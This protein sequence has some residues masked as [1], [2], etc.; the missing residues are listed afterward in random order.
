MYKIIDIRHTG[1]FG[2]RGTKRR[3]N[4]YRKRIGRT[5]TDELVNSSKPGNQLILQYVTDENG[6]DYS[7]KFLCCS[8]LVNKSIQG[9]EVFLET[10][11][12][13]YVLEKI[14][15]KKLF[16]IIGRTSSGKTSLTKAVAKR[17][18]LKVVK[19][20]TTRPLRPG[21]IEKESDHYFI[22]EEEYP[23]YKNDI[24][25]YTE[26]NGYRYFTTSKELEECDMYVIDP[27]GYYILSNKIYSGEYLKGIKTIPIYIS[28]PYDIAKERAAERGDDLKAWD[29]RY[30]SENAQFSEFE[31]YL[32]DG[33]LEAYA[34]HN[35]GYFGDIVG[36]MK[37]II[38]KEQGS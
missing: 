31:D 12:S 6:N 32:V 36:I 38:L 9:D 7:D 19:S 11:N 8:K 25:A 28:T 4:P 20:Y 13:I 37:N 35:V 33:S 24:V 29:E 2:E 14:K 15:E 23:N 22:S 3:E 18:N 16:C 5:V 17:L 21:E 1:S 30:D 27:E 10:R 26:I 34:I